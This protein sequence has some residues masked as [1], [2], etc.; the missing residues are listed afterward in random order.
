VD[1][2]AFLATGREVLARQPFRWHVGA[3]L[4][5]SYLVDKALT[6][7]GGAALRT[8]VDGGGKRCAI[9]QATTA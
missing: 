7:A 2:V 3:E 5:V 9:A 8:P 1:A 4:V 6:F